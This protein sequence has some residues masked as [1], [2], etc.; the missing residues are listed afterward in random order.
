[1]FSLPTV[2]YV[3]GDCLKLWMEW[4]LKQAIQKAFYNNWKHNHY[5]FNVFVF[6][7]SQVTIFYL[8]NAPELLHYSVVNK[9]EDMS[10]EVQDLKQLWEKSSSKLF[11]FEKSLQL[12]IQISQILADGWKRTQNDLV[13][14]QVISSQHSAECG[15]QSFPLN[16][17]TVKDSVYY[18]ENVKKDDNLL[19]AV[20]FS[21]LELHW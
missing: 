17:S 11:I 6:V 3:M 9:I 15:T 14:R 4:S 21:T 18:K 13:K 8:V 10:G 2:V 16:M 20:Y 12:C 7:F 5:V 1:M 19:C